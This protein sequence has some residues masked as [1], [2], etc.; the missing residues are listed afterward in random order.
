MP[1]EKEELKKQLQS[2]KDN[3]EKKLSEEESIKKPNTDTQKDSTNNTTAKAKNKEPLSINVDMEV[4]SDFKIKPETTDKKNTNP[5]INIKKSPTPSATKKVEKRKKKKLPVIPLI[6]LVILIGSL[7]YVYSL[8]K[9][10]QKDKNAFEKEKTESIDYANDVYFKEVEDEVEDEEMQD[11]AVY[12]D[13][14]EVVA[15][16][17][18]ETE[19]LS[20][21]DKNNIDRQIEQRAN[22]QQTISE[23]KPLEAVNTVSTYSNNN[24]KEAETLNPELG[25]K[26]E[27]KPEINTQKV[28]SDLIKV[29]GLQHNDG[30]FTLPKKVKKTNSF[31]V[32][33]RL[34]K[35][36]IA[37]T[38]ED[39]NVMLVIKDDTGNTIK[40]DS[41]NV[42]FGK[43][44]SKVLYL[45]FYEIFPERLKT[46]SIYTFS[47]FANKKL[48]KSYQKS[49]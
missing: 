17:N 16:S 45:E 37:S 49:L 48:I 36:Q 18:S 26:E 31:K 41:K 11:F 24:Q 15:E 7:I 42:N 32:R 22:N 30:A 9:D 35:N 23:N 29:V 4:V 10:L 19:T 21:K 38:E 3:I 2:I 6:L 34:K 8:K 14:P 46:N 28:F 12:K 25:K 44:N 43:Q 39:T 13:V 27:V 40:I 20:T 47:V 1:N 5:K 33:V